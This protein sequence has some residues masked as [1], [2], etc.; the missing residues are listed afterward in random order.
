MKE[1]N[2]H[3]VWRYVFFGFVLCMT[4]IGMGVSLA[5][6]SLWP[7]GAGVAILAI[8]FVLALRARE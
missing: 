6:G 1:R 5:T 4:P 7:M 2:L 3:P 8:L